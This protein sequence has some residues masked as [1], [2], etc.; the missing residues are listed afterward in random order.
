MSDQ[1]WGLTITIA[2]GDAERV[3]GDLAIH[4]TWGGRSVEIGYTLSNEAWGRG[5]ASEAVAALV[6]RL[7]EDSAI[8]RIQAM[9][10]PDNVASARVLEGTG[11]L[12][13]GRTRLSYWVGEDNSDDLIYG[14][15][16]SDWSAWNSRSLHGPAEVKLI[17]INSDN[18]AEVRQLAT[19]KSQERF[20]APV[21]KSFANALFPELLNG[22]R[23]RA[24][25]RAVE[26]DGEI[27]GFIMLALITEA[28]PEPCLWRFLIDRKHQRRGIGTMA[29]ELAIDECMLMPADSMT[30]FWGEGPGSP[31]P[32]YLKRGFVPTGIIEDGETEARLV[33]GRLRADR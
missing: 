16:R 2:T 29:L 6:A 31:K 8:S 22:V 20:V 18:L 13:E 26:A 32:L 17:E 3:I 19:H 30:V 7:F 21:D 11:F 15:T 12:Y 23:T 27:V 1:W 5:Y 24:W 4:P 28:D 33:F 25:L 9:L 10:H 14:L